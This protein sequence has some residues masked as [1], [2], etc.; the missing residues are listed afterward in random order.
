M[1]VIY[2]H[3]FNSWV[4][5]DLKTILCGVPQG[6]ILGLLL[7]SYTLMILQIRL[8]SLTFYCLL[9]ILQFYTQVLI[10]LA[11]YRWLT[12]SLQKSATGLKPINYLLM[13][14]KQII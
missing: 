14:Q 10:L 3:N 6:S 4:K 9:M 8:H 2:V 13:L 1:I 12:G 5:S 11:K 7:L